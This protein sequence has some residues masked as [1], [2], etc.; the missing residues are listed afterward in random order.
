[1]RKN[2]IY[3]IS[4][5]EIAIYIE[6][7]QELCSLGFVIPGFD[8]ESPFQYK[9]EVPAFAGMTVVKTVSKNFR[10]IYTFSP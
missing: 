10:G 3:Q 6:Q 8:R 4:V 2:E 7:S 5:L 1:M 9:E